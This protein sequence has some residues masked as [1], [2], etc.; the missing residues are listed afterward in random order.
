M[1]SVERVFWLAM[2]T[3]RQYFE[4]KLIEFLTRQ[5]WVVCHSF[6]S[7]AE[8]LQSIETIDELIELIVGKIT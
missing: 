2:K 7:Q 6:S 5:I 3:K 1:F 4:E 8:T